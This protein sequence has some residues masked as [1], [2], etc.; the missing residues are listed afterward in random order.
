MKEAQSKLSRTWYR[1]KYGIIFFAPF[2]ILFSIFTLLPVIVAFGM[3]FTNYDLLQTPKWVGIE[4]FKLLFMEDDIFQTAVKNTVL[5]A[6][7]TGISGYIGSFL[8]AW[9]INQLRFRTAVSLAFYAP[10]ITSSIAM[11]VVWS[12]IFSPDRYG[13][14]NNLL[15]TLGIVSKPIL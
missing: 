12:Y 6:T 14:L 15:T 8:M 10:S 2:F 3:S 9:V 5:L 7:V 13:V 1:Y 4:N 11:S